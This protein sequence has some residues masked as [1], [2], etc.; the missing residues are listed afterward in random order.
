MRI[1]V[2]YLLQLLCC[3]S[4]F[5]Q[6]DRKY[7]P[8]P[9]QDTI[10]EQVYGQ[11]AIRLEHMK[12]EV[13]EPKKKI[14]NYIKYLYDERFKYVIS[15]FNEDYIINDADITPYLQQILTKIYQANPYLDN[16]TTV[17]AYRSSVP[18]AFS[19]GDGTLAVTLG[20][21]NRLESESQLA[22]ILCHELAHY[23]QKHADN[24][25][26]NI[27][28]LN[29]DKD[30]AKKLWQ[31]NTYA[32]RKELI[33]DL[34]LSTTKHSRNHEFEADSVGMTYY[35][36]TGYDQQAP[37]ECMEILDK[38]DQVR[39][40]K[41]I[42]FKKRF[43]LP[44]YP[45]K[46]AWITYEKSTMW[47]ISGK[48]K[49]FG[50]SDTMRTHPNCRK[51]QAALK[52]QLTNQPVKER[53]PTDALKFRY[54]AT[55]SAFEEIASHYHFKKYGKALFG[56]LLLLEQYP[57]NAYLHAM[58]GKCLYQ[59]HIYQK[60]HEI[61]KVLELP[62]ARFDENYDR[63]LTFV[64]QLRLAEIGSLGY[65]YIESRKEKD[66]ADEE[67][68][69]AY[70]LC[71]QLPNSAKQPAQVRDEYMRKFPHGKYAQNMK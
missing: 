5:A 24:Q 16:E 1:I 65:Y 22:F 37:G 30:L 47:S 67:F 66:A 11:L 8:A 42:D 3:C 52:R 26:Q 69:Y 27:A 55:K 28:R 60:N 58:V 40:Q 35:M 48:D 34:E 20:L 51:R 43:D 56:A 7:I 64:H 44:S 19:F 13:A 21:L 68:W 41:L 54:I 15:N 31:N 33:K 12:S 62:G 14:N 18:N 49:E 46:P 53:Y 2:T 63:F 39:L 17:Y 71:S 29:F 38:A 23:H 59:L 57:D 36:H 9:I 25:I 32:Y 45:F 70:W 4:A 6:F 10:P 61:G 50:D